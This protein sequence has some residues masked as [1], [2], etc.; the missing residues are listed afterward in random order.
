LKS[1]ESGF[2]VKAAQANN[3]GGCFLN[4]IGR[5]TAQNDASLNLTKLRFG[6]EGALVLAKWLE[7]NKTLHELDVRQNLIRGNGAATL[8]KVCI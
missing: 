2:I 6:T 4:L 3:V 7:K 8:A 5:C 1:G